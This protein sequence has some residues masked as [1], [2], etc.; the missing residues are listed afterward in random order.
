MNE[1]Q[2]Q[3][4]EMV[5]AA[6]DIA[7]W[8]TTQ[9][10]V[11]AGTLLIVWIVTLVGLWMLFKRLEKRDQ[12]ITDLKCT[13]AKE[14]AAAKLEAEADAEKRV[15]KAWQ[16]VGEIFGSVN[17]LFGKVD[18]SNIK[19]AELLSALQITLASKGITAK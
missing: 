6:S 5:G 18:A 2:A 8:Y 16:R 12:E 17:V 19:T 11:A 3:T 1:A 15:D 14:I 4:V 10:G 7:Q 9:A 13:C